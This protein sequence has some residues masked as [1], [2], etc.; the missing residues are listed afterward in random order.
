MV[1]DQLSTEKREGRLLVPFS[2][3]LLLNQRKSP[4]GEVQSEFRFIHF[5]YYPKGK[6]VNG[7]IADELCYV[8]YALFDMTVKMVRSWDLGAMMGKYNIKSAFRLLPGRR[9]C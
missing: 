7:G 8:Q 2:M 3:F 1:R 5:L 4:L 9:F 6:S